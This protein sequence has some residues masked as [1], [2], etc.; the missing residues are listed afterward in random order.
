MRVVAPSLTFSLA[1]SLALVACGSPASAGG[2]FDFLFGD[3][4]RPQPPAPVPQPGNAYATPSPDGSQFGPGPGAAIDTGTGRATMFCVRM[5]DG[6]YYPIQRHGNASPAQMCSAMCPAAATQIFTGSSIDHASAPGVGAYADIGNAYLYRK[7]L[8]AT[9]TCNGK[10][11]I[12]LAT[13][14]VSADPTLRA[15]DLIATAAG[16]VKSARPVYANAGSAAAIP[17]D[18]DVVGSIRL[19]APAAPAAIPPQ[20]PAE[21][22]RRGFGFGLFRW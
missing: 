17:P 11:P 15:G 12:G 13:L 9:C 19:P 16:T 2:L 22:P 8:V 4:S 6:R 14:D 21:Q 3:N 18:G 7:K 20:P 5:C 1:L 10:D